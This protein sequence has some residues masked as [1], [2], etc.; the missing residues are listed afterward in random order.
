M[1]KDYYNEIIPPWDSRY[2][3]IGHLWKLRSL[4]KINKSK[5]I[6]YYIDKL[7]VINEIDRYTGHGNHLLVNKIGS[8]NYI[9]SNSIGRLI[10][11]STGLGTEEYYLLVQLKINNKLDKPRCLYCKSYLHWYGRLSYGYLAGFCNDKCSV[12][13]RLQ[14]EI[15]GESIFNIGNNL[16]YESL[17]LG[18]RNIIVNKGFLDDDY[19]FYIAM[20]KDRTNYYKFGVCNNP[21]TRLSYSSFNGYYIIFHILFKSTRLEIANLEANLKLIY[22][23][24]W[25]DITKLHDFLTN[26]RRISS[27][28]PINDP[29]K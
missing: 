23:S 9:C 13:Y 29:F 27:I 8:D 15:R 16:D 25:I 3:K 12:E 2:G 24:E 5:V 19:F 11:E 26:Y 18:G 1:L 21:N 10:K 20:S 28:R 14:H 6:Y 7:L 22:K 4:I 17:V